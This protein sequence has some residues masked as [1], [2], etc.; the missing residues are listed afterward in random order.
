MAHPNLYK[1]N[2]V[3]Q[4]HT[5]QGT[6]IHISHPV[7]GDAIIR[8]HDA[9]GKILPGEENTSNPRRDVVAT[10][11]TKHIQNKFKQLGAAIKM[12]T[13]NEEYEEYEE[14]EL[15]DAY[16]D[17]S[18]MDKNSVSKYISALQGK[19]AT[20]VDPSGKVIKAGEKLSDK[21]KKS[22]DLAASKMG[23]KGDYP[24]AKVPAV[25]SSKREFD[26]KNEEYEEEL[27]EISDELRKRYLDR[28]IS[29]NHL[30]TLPRLQV[31][32]PKREQQIKGLRNVASKLKKQ[33]EEHEEYEELEEAGIVYH[34]DNKGGEIKKGTAIK[35]TR[36]GQLG[37]ANHLQFIDGK[38]LI[39]IK[40]KGEGFGKT[41][42]DH[43]HNFE[44]IGTPKNPNPWHR[45]PVKEEVEEISSML[46]SILSENLV[47]S[48]DT[49]ASI[50]S[51]KIA[52]KLEEAKIIVAQS[53]FGESKASDAY[54]AGDV[55][56]KHAKKAPE[57]Q[58]KSEEVDDDSFSKSLHG[59]LKT[60]ED[61]DNNPVE[62]NEKENPNDKRVIAGLK[63]RAA[64]GETSVPNAHRNI[65]LK[66]G[67]VTLKHGDAK[68]INSFLG[69]LKPEKRLE[70]MGHMQKSPEH[71]AKIHDVIKKF[72]APKDNTSIYSAD[73]RT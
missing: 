33:N 29:N 52:Q 7:F 66:S 59:K 34:I 50:L 23:W 35:N 2:I 65:D 70:V 14:N 19:T 46:E 9:E 21:R 30:E 68:Q 62:D 67:S 71:F 20:L 22:S 55:F 11:Q 60:A 3:D 13:K 40:H 48:T 41:T 18:E 1:D 28:S 32:H 56:D 43:A 36:T 25:S 73:P 54:T 37:T 51:S 6:H 63:A 58:E 57:K 8:T 49:F 5:S 42:Q 4:K 53:L 31:G 15:I 24:A 27:A 38:P 47:E 61:I 39:T 72:P 10:G 45:G 17:L 69:G 26:K 16:S 12:P 44:T 64:K